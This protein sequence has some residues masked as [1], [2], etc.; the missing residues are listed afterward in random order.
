MRGLLGSGDGVAAQA[1]SNKDA[2]SRQSETPSSNPPCDPFR[3]NLSAIEAVC[4]SKTR[5]KKLTPA[6]YT[7]TGRRMKT[8]DEGGA[9]KSPL[10]SEKVFSLKHS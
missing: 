2:S 5:L 10:A 6:D 4:L 7:G 1:L 3:L 8:I 9:G